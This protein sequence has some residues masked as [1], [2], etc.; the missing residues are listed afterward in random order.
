MSEDSYFSASFSF[1]SSCISSK[2]SFLSPLAAPSSKMAL[3]LSPTNS[4][5]SPSRPSISAA[6]INSIFSLPQVFLISSINSIISEFTCLPFSKASSIISSGNS[7]APASTIT[8]AS[9]V[10]EIVKSNEPSLI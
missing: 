9:F 6:G 4:L 2:T 10:L 5:I 1:N 3:T 7:D 8:T